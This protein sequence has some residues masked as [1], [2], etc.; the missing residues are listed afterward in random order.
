MLRV[1]VFDAFRVFVP[2]ERLGTAWHG[3]GRLGTAWHGLAR[4]GTAWHGLGRPG[5]A[6]GGLAR[7]SAWELGTPLLATL[8]VATDPHAD[9]MGRRIVVVKIRILINSLRE[10]G[11][12]PEHTSR[13]G[14]GVEVQDW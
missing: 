1:R 5:T 13:E 4:P 8:V 10:G 6:W 11:A 7:K 14:C 9:R 12:L 2:V 3:L